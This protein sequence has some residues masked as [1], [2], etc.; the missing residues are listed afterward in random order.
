MADARVRRTV[1]KVTTRFDSGAFVQ[2][3]PGQDSVHAK[4]IKG[5]DGN[6]ALV[7][8]PAG[9]EV[10]AANILAAYDAWHP[11]LIKLAD[12]HS[13]F[14]YARELANGNRQR[15][16]SNSAQVVNLL[17]HHPHI[18]FSRDD[19]AVIVPRFAKLLNVKASTDVI[20]LVNKT[21]Q[22]GLRRFP[23]TVDGVTVYQLPRLEYDDLRPTIRAKDIRGSEWVEREK[24]R[25]SEQYLRYAAGTMEVGHRDP[26]RG[27][28]EHYE[29]A[30]IQPHE[31]NRAYK[32]RF[33]F[34]AS[35]LPRRPLPRELEKQVTQEETAEGAAEYLKAVAKAALALGVPLDDILADLTS[36]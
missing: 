13:D 20:Q 7:L 14:G 35:G 34:D 36:E 23:H 2:P 18:C 29:N 21:D 8:T 3:A 5:S 28:G 10:F 16:S 30:V 15:L 19:L 26:R 33:I 9:R 22:A 6:P 31:I 1:M 11:G 12:E 25:V 32:D 24:G 17:A 27:F 4:T